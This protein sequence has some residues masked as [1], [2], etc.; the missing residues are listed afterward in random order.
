MGG[1]FVL[2]KPTAT[3]VVNLPGFGLASGDWHFESGY[4]RRFELADLDQLFVAGAARWRW[5]SAAIG[6]SQFGKTDLY[7][8]Q[9]LKGS[10]AY[11]GNK[12]TVGGSLSAMQVQF[13]DGYGSLRAATLGLGTAVRF[14]QVILAL[15]ADNLTRPALAA[16]SPKREPVFS[17]HAELIR[18]A[19]Y[20]VTG[21]V[22]VEDR[23]KP[24]FAIGQAI[25]LSGHS[26]FFWGLSTAPLEFGGGIE[27]KIASGTVSYATSVHPVLGF[28]HTV[29][30]SYGSRQVYSEDG[31]EFDSTARH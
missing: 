24:Q 23:Q 27:M 28:S 3:T 25:R 22:T 7:A 18:P 21:R 9:L 30:F 20:S 17:A 10:F 14:T 19:S 13:G 11:H 2:S 29:S 16:N 15:E 26:S 12:F 6:V 1:T 5:F 31:D 4:N 8:E